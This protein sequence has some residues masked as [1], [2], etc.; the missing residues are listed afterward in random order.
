[1]NIQEAKNALDKVINKS[2]VHMYKPVQIAEILYRDRISKDINLSKIETYRTASKSWRDV[3]CIQFL[4]RISASSARYQDDIFNKN[5]ATKILSI[6]GKENRKKNG[7]VESYIYR[8]F[9]DKYSQMSIGLGYC[10]KNDKNKF[11]L[12][13]F[14]SFFWNEP[15]LRRSIDKIY[16][17]IVYAL[18]SVL[19]DTIEITV[20]VSLN[21][22]K[23]NILKEFEDFTKQIINLSVDNPQFRIPAKIYRVGVTNAADRGLDMW[24]NFGLVI[25]IKHLS[26]DEKL[27]EDVVNSISADRIV[28]VCKEV[29]EKVI[30]SILNQI[31]WKS[32]IQSIITEKNLI[33]WYERALRGVY[34]NILGDKL[35]KI[36]IE[37]IR[38]EFPVSKN[39]KFIR[40]YKNR[41]Y[42]KL[43]DKIWN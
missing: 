29:E 26:L 35:L 24:A 38:N 14:L 9:L 3:I 34:S 27:A 10:V 19:V 16:E 4:G 41:G 42:H 23:L 33:D 8:K 22:T 30:V 18:F 7:I 1:M 11:N 37:E 6:L 39:I 20:E 15:G 31:G 21:K 12:S 17:I 36:L 32:K 40:F 13:S 5:I 25:Q 28:I 43:K 2:R